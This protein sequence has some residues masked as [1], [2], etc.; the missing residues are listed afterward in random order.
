MPQKCCLTCYQQGLQ[1]GADTGGNRGWPVVRAGY[2]DVDKMAVRGDF[3]FPGNEN[4]DFIT[5]TGIAELTHAQAPRRSR[6]ES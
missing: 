3:F 5:H 1:S 6:W 2:I 4:A